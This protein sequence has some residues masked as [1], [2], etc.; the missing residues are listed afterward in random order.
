MNLKCRKVLNQETLNR[1]FTIIADLLLM[2][3]EKFVLLYPT[4]MLKVYFQ[5][6]NKT[7]EAKYLFMNFTE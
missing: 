2:R 4:F 6:S 7:P 3:E 1:D 5:E